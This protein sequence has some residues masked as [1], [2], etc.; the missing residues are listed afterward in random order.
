MEVRFENQKYVCMQGWNALLSQW[1]I[2]MHNVWR[3]GFCILGGKR[4]VD[5]S[6]EL[7]DTCCKSSGARAH[8]LHSQHVSHFLLIHR[9]MTSAIRNLHLQ[10]KPRNGLPDIVDAASPTLFLGPAIE[11]SRS[12]NNV[13]L[14]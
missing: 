14:E 6:P 11:V 10:A 7:Y 3:T 12:K 5:S 9:D 1:G 13:P 8:E 4:A 2:F